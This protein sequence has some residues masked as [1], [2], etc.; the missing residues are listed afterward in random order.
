[1]MFE[2]SFDPEDALDR[3]AA[4]RVLRRSARLLRP[5]RREVIESC[6]L[7]VAW[8][9]STLAGP[10]LIKYGKLKFGDLTVR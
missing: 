10:Y 7:I 4:R 3:E 6:L 2:G 8:T 1:M 9:L 5:Y